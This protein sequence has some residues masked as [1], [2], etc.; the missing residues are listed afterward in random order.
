MADQEK[1]EKQKPS[2]LKKEIKIGSKNH[3]PTKKY[4]NLVPHE[5]E[6]KNKKSLLYFGI[7]VIILLL[8]VRFGVIGLLDQLSRA[9]AEYNAMKSQLDQYNAANQRYDEVK[10]EYDELTDWYMTD[11]EKNEVDK[12]GVFDML[13]DDLFPYV[14]VTSVNMTGNQISIQTGDC[15][16]D[17][18]A[19][20]I[21]KMQSDA[22]NSYVTV[23]TTDANGER[24]AA[25]NRVVANI[26]VTYV[27]G[28]AQATP[29]EGNT[30]N[31]SEEQ[32]QGVDD[33]QS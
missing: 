31:A 23:T 10:R 22:R 13:K 20:F 14:S 28:N 11:E 25:S 33:A 24:N 7:F 21:A 32:A 3:Y 27:G 8:F 5:E 16:L 17:T 12:S 30:E 4:I 1:E 6:K 9:E 26:S 29:T 15:D 2:F 19:F 18:V